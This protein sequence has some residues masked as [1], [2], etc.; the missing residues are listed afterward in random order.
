MIRARARTEGQWSTYDN[1]QRSEPQI[2]ISPSR[3]GVVVSLACV[4]PTVHPVVPFGPLAELGIQIHSACVPA[5]LAFDS[6]G[7]FQTS[8]AYP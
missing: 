2:E 7:N 3:A 5:L 1:Q 8:L 4:L 6:Y